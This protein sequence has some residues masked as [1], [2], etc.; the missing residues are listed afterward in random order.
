VEKFWRLAGQYNGKTKTARPLEP[1]CRDTNHKHGLNPGIVTVPTAGTSVGSLTVIDNVGLN[2]PSPPTR[3]ITVQP[4]VQITN[5]AAGSTVN[6]TVSINAN[7]TGAVGNSN[8]FTFMV[9]STVLSTQTTRGTSAS[10]NW[11]TNN[12]S[13]GTHTLTV[14]VT[15]ADIVD[16][17]AGHGQHKRAGDGGRDYYLQHL[18][19][20]HKWSWRS[21]CAQR[22]EQRIDYCGFVWQLHTKWTIKRH[23]RGY[24]YAFWVYV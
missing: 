9:D 24:S 19:Y 16:A 5:P 12:Q 11:N 6:G 18:R 3:T 22:H 17:N 1:T 2:D 7:V 8:T 10:T 23:I 4:A 15:D 13:V 14:S 20:Y 21:G